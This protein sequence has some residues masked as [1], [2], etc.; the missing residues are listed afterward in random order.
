MTPAVATA[1]AEPRSVETEEGASPAIVGRSPGELA[2]RRFKRDKVGVF[3]LIV[4]LMFL[5]LS[6]LAVPIVRLLGLNPY[7]FNQSLIDPSSQNPLGGFGGVSW[8][9]PFGLEPGLGRDVFSRIILG[10]QWSFSVA[11][12]TTFLTLGTG[13]VIGVTTGYLGGTFDSAVGR[14][15]DFL[16]A[17]PGFFMIIALSEPAVQRLESLPFI[18]TLYDGRGLTSKMLVMGTGAALAVVSTLLVLAVLR[19][20]R[21]RTVVLA[22]IT[23]FVAFGFATSFSLIDPWFTSS[24]VRVFALVAFLAFFGWL[25]FARLIRSQVLSLRERDFVTAARALG[26]PD[27]RIVF[28]ELI[29]NLWPPVIVFA[30]NALPG[31]LSA[32]AAFSYLGIGVQQPE[33]TWGTILEQSQQFW[34]TN[35]VFFIFP[36]ALLFIVVLAFN[37]VGDAVR[38]ALD[39]KLDR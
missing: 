6:A 20:N 27:R 13:L 36:G 7:T 22:A 16:M 26:A 10:S 28:K 15:I 9:H 34:Q 38:D 2:W 23:A 39:P 30:S 33:S 24:H 29:P 11:F 21:S 1:V 32:E 14:V 19:K 12:I 18:K 8:A 25:Y 4:S 17:F 37:L 3:A 31:Y 5:A 35:P